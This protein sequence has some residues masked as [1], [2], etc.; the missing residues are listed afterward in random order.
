MLEML[1]LTDD[2]LEAPS[3]CCPDSAE[4]T[5]LLVKETEVVT[6]VILGFTSSVLFSSFADD[7]YS[8]QEEEGNISDKPRQSCSRSEHST[9]FVEGLREE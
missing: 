4:E 1:F 3:L 9:S 7:S 5:V 8:D 2:E 6:Q